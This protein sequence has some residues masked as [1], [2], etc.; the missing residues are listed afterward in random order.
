[1]SVTISEKPWS[2]YTAAD[3]TLEQWH[4]ACLIHLHSSN[5]EYTK[6][7]C[8]LPVKTPEGT[9]NKNGVHAAAAALAGA[10]GGVKAPEDDKKKARAA[11]RRMYGLM[12]EKPP[13]S[14]RH[15]SVDSFLAH[16][17]VKGMKWRQR[18]KSF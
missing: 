5:E 3:Y 7:D 1:M 14:M 2:D 11:I 18:K 13:P 15:S 10:R 12:E 6:A 9:I 4:N 17:G 8:K 16:Y